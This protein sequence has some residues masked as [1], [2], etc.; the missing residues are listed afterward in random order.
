MPLLRLISASLLAAG[1][2][3]C[4]GKDAPADDDYEDCAWW[5]A[6][7]GFSGGLTGSTELIVDLDG[8]QLNGCH[9]SATAGL[10]SWGLNHDTTLV[11]V[12]VYDLPVGELGEADAAL[13]VADADAGS[14]VAEA[15]TVEMTAYNVVPTDDR[16]TVQLA[17]GEG[18]CDEA[19]RSPDGETAGVLPFTFAAWIITG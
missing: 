19:L 7:V 10:T 6:R 8:D 9:G 15:C 3:A 16:F 13:S 12:T 18:T 11:V 14:W 1:L 4:A 5:G 17:E 2:V